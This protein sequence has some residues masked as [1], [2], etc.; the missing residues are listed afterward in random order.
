M[1]KR[2]LGLRPSVY[3]SIG[4][5]ATVGLW[6]WSGQWSGADA[7]TTPAEDPAAE[8]E[9]APLPSVRVVDSHAELHRALL[10]IS[11]RTDY[12]K[13]VMVKSEIDGRI[14]KIDMEESHS[15][16][17]GQVIARIDID[18]RQAKLDEAKAVLDQR[19][20][21]YAAAKKLAQKGFQSEVR[22]SEAAANLSAAKSQLRQAQIDLNN[23]AITAPFDGRVQIQS[24]EVGDY[25][26]QGDPIATLVDMDPI[27]IKG[28]VSER[29]ISR[30][31]LGAEA[32]VSL[33]T[34]EK[35]TGIIS[36]IAPVADSATR[37]FEVAIEV[38]NADGH[39]PV[40]ITA[41]LSLPM[42][43]VSAHLLS[44]SLLTLSEEGKIG[45]K[46]VDKQDMVRFATITIVEDTLNGM[47]VSG[48]PDHARLI[49]VGH[50]YVKT[51][52]KVQAVNQDNRG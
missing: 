51:G 49:S 4:L 9:A 24:V 37:T 30:I 29:D 25:V 43:Q 11:G 46:Y 26:Q 17:D 33:I 18:N 36:R 20:I 32:A 44:P 42:Q 1:S 21:E 3:I 40:G 38:I 35:L 47:W 19:E 8:A 12:D 2:L 34:G 7:T 45:V 10:R 28:Q 13:Q 5:A 14:A 16:K 39:I 23:T 41:E 50:E 31:A 6:L 52:Q 15:V 22:R 48:L 27:L